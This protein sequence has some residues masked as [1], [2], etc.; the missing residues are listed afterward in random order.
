MHLRD[1]V[2]RDKGLLIDLPEEAH[3]PLEFLA[4]HNRDQLL[5]L[6][7]LI[8]P[9]DIIDRS[10]AVELPEDEAPDSLLLL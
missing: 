8:G 10:T 6:L 7:K 3:E 1:L 9:D 2:D 4:V 5:P